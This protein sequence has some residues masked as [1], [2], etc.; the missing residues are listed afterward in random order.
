MWNAQTDPH[1]LTFTVDQAEEWGSKVLKAVDG[2]LD[3]AGATS[4]TGGF[5]DAAP[6][7]Q[8]SADHNTSK[9]APGSGGLGSSVNVQAI[10]REAQ[11]AQHTEGMTKEDYLKR[12]SG[13]EQAAAQLAAAQGLAPFGN[14]NQDHN[15]LAPTASM[16]K[17]SA[18]PMEKSRNE[19]QMPIIKETVSLAPISTAVEFD[20][21]PVSQQT[22]APVGPAI[23]VPVIVPAAVVAPAVLPTRDHLEETQPFTN[24]GH[25]TKDLVAKE[26]K[27][28]TS[29][30][31]AGRAPQPD[32]PEL[33]PS[34]YIPADTPM[35]EG[36]PG[37]WMGT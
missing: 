31:G 4:Q 35:V 23:V 12:L 8:T 7:S 27:A 18:E 29:L 3:E 20:A 6:A 28:S 2:A 14:T 30:A 17:T 32:L 26:P 5:V 24:P 22:I 15:S 1:S 9:Q 34:R 13:R 25:L 10:A 21:A 19:T 33:L 36:L 16:G 37:G 11:L